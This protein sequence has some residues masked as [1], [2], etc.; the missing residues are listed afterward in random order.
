VYTKESVISLISENGFR[1]V[2]ILGDLTG[3]EYLE[4]SNTIGIIAKKA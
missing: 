4:A 3:K 1:V 2:N